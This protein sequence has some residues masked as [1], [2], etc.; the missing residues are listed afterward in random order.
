MICRVTCLAALCL[1]VGSV[2]GDQDP[3][4][5]SSSVNQL[6]DSGPGNIKQL[7]GK[8]CKGGYSPYCLKLSLIWLIGKSGS[9]NFPV[10]P[11]VSINSPGLP[12]PVV[13]QAS[14]YLSQPEKVDEVLLEKLSEYLGTMSISVKVMDKTAPIGF[15]R[16]VLGEDPVADATARKKNNYGGA[17][18][19]AGLMSGGTLLAMG[20]AALAAMCGKALM[21]SLLALMLA[22]LAALKGGG[23]GGEKTTYEIVAKPVVSHL[24]THSSEVQHGH[25]GHYRRSMDVQPI[26]YSAHIPVSR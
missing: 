7:L 2:A 18:A 19:A 22:A 6:P 9:F 20:M 16:A 4:V 17:L 5:N 13:P 10:L 1:F 3:D 25:H 15:A 24:S 14:A 23:G 8:E 12:E 11:G 26:V 21:A